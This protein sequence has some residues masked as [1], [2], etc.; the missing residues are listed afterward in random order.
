MRIPQSTRITFSANPLA[1]VICQI[2][3]PRLLEIEQEL[4]V[5]FHRMIRK[6]FPEINVR[7][8]VELTFTEPGSQPRQILT[9]H[10]DFATA[11]SADRISLTSEF[12]ALTSTKYAGWGSFRD[13][14]L[15]MLDA[16]KKVYDISHISRVGLRYR[17]II[18]RASLGLSNAP[19]E[20]LIR[21]EVMGLAGAGIF[22]DD[23]LA[24]LSCT[25]LASIER[26]TVRINTGLVKRVDTQSSGMLIDTD[27]ATDEKMEAKADVLT[28][29]LDDYN[30]KAGNF[31][32]WCITDRLRQA[33][34]P[35]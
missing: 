14:V 3:F 10:Y 21:R 4:P 25:Y 22:Q 26:G 11:D 19:W 30:A 2:K 29:V 9:S 15:S 17:N 27:F 28:Q 5:G 31:F 13:G 1:E 20:D 32:R 8:T 18:D 7:P 35:G 12:V 6:K 34:G 23:E 16:A 24:E 33:L